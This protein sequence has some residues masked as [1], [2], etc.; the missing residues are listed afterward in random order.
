M[1][2]HHTL[3]PLCPPTDKDTRVGKAKN[4]EQ[5]FESVWISS[6]ISICSSRSHLFLTR[7]TSGPSSVLCVCVCVRRLMVISDRPLKYGSSIFAVE[8]RKYIYMAFFFFNSNRLKE[9]EISNEVIT[10]ELTG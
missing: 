3:N 2:H 1:M 10:R 8:L 5:A 7:G 6:W 9:F 4:R